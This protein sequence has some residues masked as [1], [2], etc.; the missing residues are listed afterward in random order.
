MRVLK[1]SRIHSGCARAVCCPPTR[2]LINERASARVDAA[3]AP[4]LL[5]FCTPRRWVPIPS[6]S[7]ALWT[8]NAD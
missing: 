4:V 6:V 8:L 3:P 5:N 7:V 1:S 2:H